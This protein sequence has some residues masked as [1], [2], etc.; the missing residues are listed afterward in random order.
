[1]ILTPT[2]QAP[3]LGSEVILADVQYELAKQVADAIR[4]AGGQAKAVQC[5]VTDYGAVKSLVQ[6]TVNRTG[7]IDYI[8]N[9][10]GIGKMRHLQEYTIEDWQ[11]VIDVN[12]LGVVNGVHAAYPVMLKQ[13]HGHIINT[14]SMAGLMPSVRLIPYV[15]TK[16]AVVGLSKSLRAEAADTGVRVSVFCPGYI[17]TPILKIDREDPIL[18]GMSEAQLQATDALIE[19]VF[20]MDPDVFVKKALKAIAKNKAI[21]ILPWWCKIFWWINRISPSLGIKMTVKQ[22]KD[23]LKMVEKVKL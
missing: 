2:I 6:D 1:M 4:A 22:S 5:D 16:H 8:F 21:I 13:G 3:D 18:A 11:Q 15:T 23:M 19:K 10:A 14:A 20:P 17:R 12:L 7:R 9:N